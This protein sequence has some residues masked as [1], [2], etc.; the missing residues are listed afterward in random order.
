MAFIAQDAKEWKEAGFDVAGAVEW[1]RYA[2]EPSDAARWKSAEFSI[3]D[4]V[5]WRKYGFALPEAKRWRDAGHG[6][7]TASDKKR[8]RGSP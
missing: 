2:F 4:A 7:L 6:P 3:G 8:S 5:A 1:R